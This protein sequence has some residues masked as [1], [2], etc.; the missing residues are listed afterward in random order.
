MNDKKYSNQPR[1]PMFTGEELARAIKSAP[2]FSKQRPPIQRRKKS[3]IS[4]R[5]DIKAK[6]KT[7][8][9]SLTPY[10]D[11]PDFRIDTEVKEKLR[12]IQG[13]VSFDLRP[14]RLTGFGARTKVTGTAKEKGT[15]KGVPT[16]TYEETWK[17]IENN[18][19]GA[20]G[21]QINENNRIGVQLS[22]RFF[23]NQKGSDNQI[24][25]DYNVSDIGNGNLN[26]SLTGID[27]MSG[28]KTKAMNLQYRVD[29]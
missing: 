22:K 11:V 2:T 19:G 24:T 23:E 12:Q 28:K 10:S 15:Y 16:G 20:L 5:L 29:F 26:V 3:K 6:N 18:I 17:S 8:K 21:Y 13:D 4:G 7:T 1:K 27:P 14:L 25:L 9:E